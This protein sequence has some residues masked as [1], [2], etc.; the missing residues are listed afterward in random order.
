MSKPIEIFKD[1]SCTVSFFSCATTEDCTIQGEQHKAQTI[2]MKN[3]NINDTC[4]E[5][6]YHAS[7]KTV[8]C[9]SGSVQRVDKDDLNSVVMSCQ[10]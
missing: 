2:S 9:P 5:Y 1:S 6:R 8:E 3:P 10:K 4:H 7:D